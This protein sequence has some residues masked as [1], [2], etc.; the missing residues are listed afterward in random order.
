[1][2]HDGSSSIIM[3]IHHD[4]LWWFVILSHHDSSCGMIITHNHD[5]QWWFPG[6]WGFDRC[7]KQG[8]W[9]HGLPDL[10]PNHITLKT[11]NLGTLLGPLSW[12]RA[13]QMAK[14]KTDGPGPRPIWAYWPCLGPKAQTRLWMGGEDDNMPIWGWD[15][16]DDTICP[17]GLLKNRAIHWTMSI[18]NEAHKSWK[19]MFQSGRVQRSLREH[20]RFAQN[21]EV[22]YSVCRGI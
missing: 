5:A 22:M 18:T 1:M 3:M 19:G 14:W 7:Y 2:T 15:G 12:C 20:H 21:S 9:D 10:A 17:P 16:G 6:L 13:W 4:D 11:F 8:W